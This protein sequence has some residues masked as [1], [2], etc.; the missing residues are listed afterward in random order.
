MK[1]LPGQRARGVYSL[2]FW[3]P[4]L[5]GAAAG[6]MWILNRALSPKAGAGD[7]RN[8]TRLLAAIPGNNKAAVAAVFGPPRASAGFSALAPAMLVS[9]DYLHADTWYY[10]LDS[11][12]QT[13][14]VVHFNKDIA[15]D[16]QLVDVPTA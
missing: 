4:A 10:P 16:A 11:G 13:A 3:L 14:L 6:L 15:K 9:S 5:G 7:K 8:A 2:F 1:R 12:T